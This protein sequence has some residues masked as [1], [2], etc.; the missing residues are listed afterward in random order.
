MVDLTE[1]ESISPYT[2]EQASEA[3]GKLAD[4]PAV[5]QASRYFFPEES[6]DLSCNMINN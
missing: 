2:D 1:F 4:H 5:A 3:L 6:P